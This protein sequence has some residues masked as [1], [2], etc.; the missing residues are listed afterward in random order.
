MVST[1]SP[2]KFCY[3]VLS[4]LG[5]EQ[6][7]EGLDILDQL[8][9]KTGLSAP[10]PLASLRGKAVRFDQTVEKERMV[11]AVLGMLE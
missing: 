4:A 7:A 11:D 8:T 9:E 5:E 1:A 2:F 10:T 3:S 6:H